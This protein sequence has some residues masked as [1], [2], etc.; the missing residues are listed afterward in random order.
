MP[1]RN[2][3]ISPRRWGS[4]TADECAKLPQMG[5]AEISALFGISDGASGEWKR[6]IE[7]GERPYQ[8]VLK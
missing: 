1:K 6:R 4:L 3:K 5:R 8:K 7:A 2:G